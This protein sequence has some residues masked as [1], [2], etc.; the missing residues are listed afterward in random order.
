MKK[1]KSEKHDFQANCMK[2]SPASDYNKWI[3]ILADVSDEECFVVVARRVFE[4][5][6]NHF[7]SPS[8]CCQ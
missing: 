5:D 3:S 1:R 2:L 7:E 8:N 4:D 6:P